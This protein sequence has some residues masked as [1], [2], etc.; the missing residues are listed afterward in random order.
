MLGC[1]SPSAKNYNPAA[2]E[3]D[4]SCIYLNNIGGQCYEF[5]DVQ[6]DQLIDHSFTLSMTVD[7]DTLQPIGWVFYHDYLPDFYIHTRDM[8][9][10]LS[11]NSGFYQSKGPRGVYHN[12]AVVKPFFVDVLFADKK[13]MILNSVNWITEVRASGNDEIDDNQPALFN[14]TL[15]AITIWNNYQTSGRIPLDKGIIS[16]EKSN[17]RNSEQTWNFNDFRNVLSV[18][19]QQFI[20]DLFHDFQVDPDKLSDNLPWFEKRLIEGN[21]FIVRFEFDNNNNKQ[22]TLHNTDVD[23]SQS[24]R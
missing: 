4:G 12:Q 5:G 2:T 21:Y 17:D 10:N 1:T 20:S 8:L 14:E 6:A 22:I 24:Y 23:V 13:N 16:L 15:T 7:K 11:G 18:L 3:D 9:M 19:D